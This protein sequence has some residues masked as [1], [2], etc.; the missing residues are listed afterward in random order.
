[1]NIIQKVKELNLPDGS[2]VVEGSAVMDILGIRKAR[3]I[4]L[5]VSKEVYTKLKQDREWK[6]GFLHDT[7][8][9]A[10]DIYE[11]WLEWD[12]KDNE[13]NLEELLKD[14]HVIDGVPFVNIKRLLGWKKRR[15]LEKDLV[16]IK[17]IEEYLGDK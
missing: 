1:M 5:V 10:K 8:F 7:N 13:P 9:L 2:Y 11:I 14:A 16:D 12:S 15:K 17:L 4:D 6:E 3:D